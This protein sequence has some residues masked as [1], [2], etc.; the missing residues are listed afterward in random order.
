MPKITD[1]KVIR[2]RATG[3]WVIVKILTDQ[4][5]LWGI[6]SAHEMNATGAVVAALEEW[7]KPRLIGRDVSHIE[8]IW[9]TTFTSGYW[10][11][12]PV[13]NVALGGIDVALWDIKGKEAGMR[14][15]RYSV[16]SAAPRP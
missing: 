9:Q 16:E 4:P 1:M 15:T 12:G 11:T 14:C 5:G 2:T 3:T 7:F 13:H 8:D 6:G 10:R